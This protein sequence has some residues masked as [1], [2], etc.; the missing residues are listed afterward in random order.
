[1]MIAAI[2]WWYP[3]VTP[4]QK[5]PK[6]I[7]AVSFLVLFSWHTFQFLDATY[8]EQGYQYFHKTM[9]LL[10]MSLFL[11]LTYLYFHTLAFS[12]F[13]KS[14]LIHL[15]LP[16]IIGIMAIHYVHNS[17]A[18]TSDL[19][20]LLVH[21]Q[22][23]IYWILEINLVIKLTSISKKG[24]IHI[25]THWI[26][27]TLGFITIQS[28]LFFPYFLV[29]LTGISL[30]PLLRPEIIGIIA[31][32]M[33]SL[34]LFFQPFLLFGIRDIKSKDFSDKAHFN[35]LAKGLEKMNANLSIEEQSIERYVS[36]HHPYLNKDITL[37]HMAA[38]IGV[39]NN[40]IKSYLKKKGVNFEEYLN[41]KRILF[42]QNIIKEKV[43]HDMTLDMLAKQSGF[44]DRKSF[45]S[46]F[47]KHTGYS[48]SDYIK[49][50]F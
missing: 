10:S 8:M 32:F 26:R 39:S 6:R 27:W 2:L 34:S 25:N 4:G 41:L 43:Y 16:A 45:I 38:Q 5:T 48:P 30:P 36:K 12:S 42:S 14:I 9:V 22:M 49:H 11:P 20:Y 35:L 19:P 33:L 31:G 46:S 7:L 40:C 15:V 3:N 47:K 50:F 37:D 21:L 29:A 44:I 17:N 1:M 28:L 23:I 24:L 13:G 18:I